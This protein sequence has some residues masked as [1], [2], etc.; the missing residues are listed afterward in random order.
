M[1]RN[2]RTNASRDL[3]PRRL[4]RRR[5]P[6]GRHEQGRIR[7]RRRSHC[8]KARIGLSGANLR[9]RGPN[10]LRL[11]RPPLCLCVTNVSFLVF[12]RRFLGE[13]SPL[14]MRRGGR[15]IKKMPRSL[16]VGADGVVAHT[17]M[18]LVSDHPICGAKVG[19]A[20]IFLM[21]Q[22]PLLVRRGLRAPVWLRPSR[23]V[24]LWFPTMHTFY[25]PEVV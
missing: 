19:C 10:H 12:S 18:C 8:C 4:R 13:R 15:D 7:C 23:A 16:L 2:S 21:P 6:R 20:E 22:P 25:V 3:C 9:T 14:L 24:S 17:G 11:L 1:E 5:R